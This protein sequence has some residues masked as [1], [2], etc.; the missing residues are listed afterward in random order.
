MTFHYTRYSNILLQYDFI[1]V[2]LARVMRCLHKDWL[3]D[4]LCGVNLLVC[5]T[6]II[7][8]HMMSWKGPEKSVN[9]VGQWTGSRDVK[10][11]QRMALKEEWKTNEKFQLQFIRIL[12]NHI[13]YII[14]TYLLIECISKALSE[15]RWTF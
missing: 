15:E 3:T 14:K 6:C 10:G 5:S 2:M 13:K 11:L 8:F 9:S 12:H 1:Y 7:F 4:S